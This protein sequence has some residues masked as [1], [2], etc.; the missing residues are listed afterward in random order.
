[1]LVYR[2][3]VGPHLAEAPAVHCPVISRGGRQSHSRE[4]RMDQFDCLGQ[5]LNHGGLPDAWL[6]T[7]LSTGS[8]RG[9][10]QQRQ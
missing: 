5:R 10:Q 9:S 6:S 2:S 3:S 4:A 1:M 7:G 8:S